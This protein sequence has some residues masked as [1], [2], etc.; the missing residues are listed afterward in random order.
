MP[1]GIIVYKVAGPLQYFRTLFESVNTI[2][3]GVADLE[4]MQL[5]E[6]KVQSESHMQNFTCQITDNFKEAYLSNRIAKF[7]LQSQGFI[8]E[9]DFWN[10][11]QMHCPIISNQGGGDVNHFMIKLLIAKASF[12]RLKKSLFLFNQTKIKLVYPNHLQESSL[13][14]YKRVPPDV[15]GQNRFRL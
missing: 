2:L 8:D 9:Q 4:K 13:T 11:G 14:V 1:L 3:A 5:Q 15:D 7:C 10:S 12:S 6:K